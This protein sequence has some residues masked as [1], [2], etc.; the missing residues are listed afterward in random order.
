[1][2]GYL[3]NAD[4]KDGRRGD[5]L[6]SKDEGNWSGLIE[7]EIRAQETGLTSEKEF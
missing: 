5:E 2:M 4:I 7:K 3:I 6:D 1:M